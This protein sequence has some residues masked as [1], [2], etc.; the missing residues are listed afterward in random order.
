LLV[1][2]HDELPPDEPEVPFISDMDIRLGIEDR[3]RAAWTDFS[4]REW[5]GA[6]VLAGAVLEA[7]LLWA[8][9]TARLSDVPKRPLDELRLVDLIRLA[10]SNRIID[11]A[12][13]R[14]AGLAKDARNIQAR[15][16]VQVRLAIKQRL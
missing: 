16:S 12:S 10:L 7:L 2:C 4:A 6:T 14:Q 1:K 11:D 8:L 13:A 9:K 15:R 3:I 5:L